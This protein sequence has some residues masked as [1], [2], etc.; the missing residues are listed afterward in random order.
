MFLKEAGRGKTE[1][2]K[3]TTTTKKKE[4]A[5]S[6]N[7][8]NLALLA[9]FAA[10]PLLSNLPPPSNSLGECL[11]I[12]SHARLWAQLFSFLSFCAGSVPFYTK[13]DLA[14]LFRLVQMPCSSLERRVAFQVEM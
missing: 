1:L 4:A 12:L 2:K 13:A 14:L 7:T 10:F 11:G 9:K 3:L 8:S 6:S 5:T